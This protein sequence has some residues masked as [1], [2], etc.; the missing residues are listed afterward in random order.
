M[1]GIPAPVKDTPY[2]QLRHALF[3][4]TEGRVNIGSMAEAF[5]VSKGDLCR[6]ERGQQDSG[7][8]RRPEI[9]RQLGATEEQLAWLTRKW[10]AELPTPARAI[11]A[12]NPLSPQAQ[13]IL[14]GYEIW[15]ELADQ[16]HARVKSHPNGQSCFLEAYEDHA[17]LGVLH[18][19]PERLL[20]L[21][22]ALI[23]VA[24]RTLKI[25]EQKAGQSV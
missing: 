9:W 4:H 21:G 14:Q 23:D 5:G 7:P 1:N 13:D 22:K 24:N 8:L 2:T 10:T 11:V 12:Q 17:N 19:P 15:V 16:Q 25:Q 18:L 3:K 6:M 20:S